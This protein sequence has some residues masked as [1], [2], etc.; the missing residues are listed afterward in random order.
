MCLG[1]GAGVWG[2]E[3]H[4]PP[5]F[6]ISY[7]PSPPLT[8]TL[9]RYERED[10]AYLPPAHLREARLFREA[11]LRAYGAA[12]PAA[13]GATNRAYG[14]FSSPVAKEGAASSAHRS[15]DQR[16]DSGE[17]IMGSH[18]LRSY[19]PDLGRYYMWCQTANVVYLAVYVPGEC[20]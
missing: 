13:E 2:K 3:P 5:P 4:C 17:P 1:G 11:A 7:P 9:P 8:D 15:V 10:P 6:P 18:P 12:S 20:W 16:V 14:A 19:S